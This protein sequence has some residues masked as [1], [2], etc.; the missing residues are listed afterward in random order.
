MV[1]LES[2]EL[3][4]ITQRGVSVVKPTLIYINGVGEIIPVI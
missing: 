3:Y 2:I 4:C 1:I